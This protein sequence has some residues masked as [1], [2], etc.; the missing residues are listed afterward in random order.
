MTPLTL[1]DL[2][3]PPP[4]EILSSWLAVFFYLVG[5]TTAAI[6][7]Y[8]QVTGRGSSTTISDQPLEVK[9]HA[10][11]ATL[12]QLE[13]V[14]NET[15]GRIKRERGEI[16]A[17][18]QRVEEISERKFDKIEEKIDENTKL[19]AGMNGEMRQ[20]NQAVTQLTSSLTNFMRDQANDS[21]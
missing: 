1:A 11:I 16:D 8:R 4:P 15:H 7:L 18:I 14:K 9:E 19:T 5:G 10:G 20:I 13:A 12:Q 21:R 6:I 17:R 3:A 2:S